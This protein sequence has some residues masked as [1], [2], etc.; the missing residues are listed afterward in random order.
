[1]KTEMILIRV[2]PFNPRKSAF[3]SFVVWMAT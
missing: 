2:D 1:M 3:Y